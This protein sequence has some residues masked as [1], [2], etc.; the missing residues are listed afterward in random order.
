MAAIVV[1]PSSSASSSG[2]WSTSIRFR[3]GLIHGKWPPA[4]VF[5]IERRN[6]SVRFAVVGHLH[7]CKASRPASV[8]IGD[9]GYR[10]DCAKRLKQIAQVCFSHAERKVANEYLLHGFPL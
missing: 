10:F 1:A 8:A 2:S 6:G 5:A 9:Y 7:K 3:T 4:A